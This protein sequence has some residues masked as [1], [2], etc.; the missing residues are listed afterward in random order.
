MEIIQKGNL[1]A[2]VLDFYF[3]SL[4][5]TNNF[6]IQFTKQYKKINYS[7]Y[8]NWFSIFIEI[9]QFLI[10]EKNF[11]QRQELSNRIINYKYVRQYGKT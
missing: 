11:P 1:C 3:A 9:L 5:I 4:N 2:C 7:R 10:I 6:F 8:L